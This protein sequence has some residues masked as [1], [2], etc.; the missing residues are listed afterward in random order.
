MFSKTVSASAYV[1]ASTPGDALKSAFKGS[2]KLGSFSA[3][4][5]SFSQKTKTSFKV[6]ATSIE[7]DNFP[8]TGVVFQPFEELKKDV[9]AVPIAPQVSTARQKYTDECEAAVNEQIKWVCF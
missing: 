7:A 4:A 5:V 2:S 1:S 8:L 9:L 3:S 6:S